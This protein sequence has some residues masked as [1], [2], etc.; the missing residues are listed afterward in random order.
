MAASDIGEPQAK[1]FD[2]T[3]HIARN[4]TTIFEC[5]HGHT[6][7]HVSIVIHWHRIRVA[8]EISN[9]SATRAWKT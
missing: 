3:Q 6:I 4:F 7:K 5:A 1:L 9:L 2:K 8:C